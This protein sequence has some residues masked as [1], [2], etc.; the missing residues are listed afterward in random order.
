MQKWA[1]Q[2]AKTHLSKVVRQAMKGEPQTIILRGEDAVVV[3]SKQEYE[4]LLSPRVSFLELMQSSPLKGLD[5]LLERDDSFT[6]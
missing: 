5:L 1:L 4:A 2:D 3:L 6:G